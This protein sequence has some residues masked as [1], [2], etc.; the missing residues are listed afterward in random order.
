[1]KTAIIII[2]M[3]LIAVMRIFIAYLGLEEFE[4]YFDFVNTLMLAT[5]SVF[6][7]SMVLFLLKGQINERQRNASIRN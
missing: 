7:L 2:T 5:Y 6:V 1:M 4:A 3:Q